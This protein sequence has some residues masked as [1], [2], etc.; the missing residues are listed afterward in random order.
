MALAESGKAIGKISELLRQHLNAVTNVPVTVGR[1]EPPTTTTNGSL[2]APRLNLFLY[3]AL[4]D[5][6]LRNTALDAG[7]P[8]PLWLVL[9][10]LITSFDEASDSDS[11]GAQ[12]ALGEA[13]RALQG[14][15]FIPFDTIPLPAA[16]G[17]QPALE[18]NP[19][20]LK[21][22]FRETPADRLAQLMQ[23]TD[24]KYRFSMGF[25]V[26]PVMIATADPPAYDLLVGVDYT[27]ATPQVI[28]D[29]GVQIPVL[30]TL[31]P[32]ISA[33]SPAR[34]EPG[35]TLTIRGSSLN[36][37][38]LVVQLGP[39]D[40]GITAQ[41]PDR[42]QCAVNGAIPEGEVISAGS[43]PL[44]VAQ[45]LPDGKRRSS[46]LLIADLAPVLTAAVPDGV[47]RVD[48]AD[49]ASDV[50]GAIDLEGVLL[51][52]DGDDAVLALYRDGA[53][54]QMVTTFTDVPAAPPGAPAQTQRR[55]AMTED[56]AV[57]PG[58]YRVILRVNGQQARMSPTVTLTAP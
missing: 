35:A 25:E 19:E 44:A 58:R 49:P 22:T 56:D 31:G 53:V 6:H 20:T 28:G 47:T 36:T 50:F 42:V 43:H 8:P 52:T 23:G 30:P 55:A 2:P 9:R 16:L 3:E 39:A 14:L 27:Q 51:G 38:G 29:A 46:N 54:V 1:P 48:A 33:V 10:Y 17:I 32:V 15:S 26:G 4:F 13:I 41:R 57:P 21:I 40:L 11:V 12:E 5:P 24:E 37:S 45:V 7:Q 18:D 34:F